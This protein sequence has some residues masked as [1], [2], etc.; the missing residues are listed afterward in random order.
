MMFDG[1]PL[2]FRGYDGEYLPLYDINNNKKN[3]IGI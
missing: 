2:Y 3:H 1:L